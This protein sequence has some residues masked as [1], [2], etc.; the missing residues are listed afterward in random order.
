IPKIEWRHLRIMLDNGN[1]LFVQRIRQ[2]T[3]EPATIVPAYEGVVF[4][5]DDVLRATRPTWIDPDGA[6]SGEALRPW[7]MVDA[8]KPDPSDEVANTAPTEPPSTTK[9][10]EP[11]EISV[12]AKRAN[13]IKIAH[14]FVFKG[15]AP[16]LKDHT[17]SVMRELGAGPVEYRMLRK[18][19]EAELK[20]EFAAVR[21][22]QGNP[23]SKRS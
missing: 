12:E 14:M 13:V 5:R 17:T 11:V 16:N 10:S 9:R 19:V 3:L 22:K 23:H 2:S 4:V 6:R 1:N 15:M 21:R 7:P 18:D 8:I 20:I